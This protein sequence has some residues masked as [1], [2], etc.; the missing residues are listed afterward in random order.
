MKITVFTSNQ[1]RH[2][3]L[4]NG[5]AAIAD[6]CVAVM[7]ANTVFPGQVDDFFRKSD[8]MQTYFSEVIASERRLFGGI[9]ATAEN[10]RSLVIKMGDL[11][12]LHEDALAPALDADLFVVFGASYIKGWLIDRLVAA[13]AI[14]INMG[15]SPYY[16]GS[17]C[18]FWALFDDNPHLVGSTI[19]LLSKGL[20]SGPMLYHALPDPGGCE[21]PFDFSMKAVAAAHASLI[22][23]I[24]D[25]SVFDGEPVVQDA[26]DTVRYT[27][28][29]DFTDDVARAYLDRGDTLDAIARRRAERWD[30]GL[31]LKPFVL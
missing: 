28:N 14:N 30:D 6:E 23:R 29:R 5:L 25:G 1:P 24:S 19:H 18:N 20:D 9:A 11:N 13:K 15:V 31:F 8:V 12:M 22:A 4:I 26:A 7:E 3:H 27:R 10:V 17:S 2:L 16:K 21:T